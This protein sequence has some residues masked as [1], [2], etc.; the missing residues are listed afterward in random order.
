MNSEK[1]RNNDFYVIDVLHI[2]RS[3]WR[4]AWVVV[5]CVILAAGIGFSVAA[6]AIAPTYSSAIM[7][8]INN[9]SVSIGDIGVSFSS[10]QLSAAQ[11]LV[12][13]Y[14]VL[15]KN[16]TTLERV[17]D[18]TGVSYDWQELYGMLEVSSVNDT[19]IM[20]VRVTTTDPYEAEKIAN[21]IAVILPKRVA[22]VIEGASVEIVDAAVAHTEKVGPSVT[23][24]TGIGGILG[25]LLAVVAL[26]VLALMDNTIHDDDYILQNYDYPILAK[27]PNLL[28]SS[29]GKSGYRYA[30]YYR[31]DSK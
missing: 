16:R 3:L 7:L 2:V 23:K 19:E 10:S 8:Y 21:G 18:H 6:F 1:N 26:I 22:E 17:I 29:S 20:R 31:K 11:S 27:I 28:E 25:G 30:N 13:T 14:S 5:L 4:R 24:Y 15:L 12:K 9:G